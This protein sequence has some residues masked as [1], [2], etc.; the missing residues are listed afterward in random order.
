[1][2]EL[3]AL[4]QQLFLEYFGIDPKYVTF[5]TFVESLKN[6]SNSIIIESI[7]EGIDV[8][9]EG[10]FLSQMRN[11]STDKDLNLSDTDIRNKLKT[12]NDEKALPDNEKTVT[13]REIQR[14]ILNKLIFAVDKTTSNLQQAEDLYSR[15]IE[16]LPEHM[17]TLLNFF[18][19]PPAIYS[20]ENQLNKLII[21]NAKYDKTNPSRID[22]SQGLHVGAT[23]K[24]LQ[25][26]KRSGRI[27][28]INSDGTVRV[29]WNQGI[30]NKRVI[31]PNVDPEATDKDGE[32]LYD[33]YDT[34]KAIETVSMNKPSENDEGKQTELIHKLA[35]PEE[36]ND[37]ERISS[38]LA[39]ADQYIDT[40]KH[41]S[42]PEK[43][44]LKLMT[45]SENVGDLINKEL[46]AIAKK[47]LD[48]KAIT[49]KKGVE[50]KVAQ[51]T[52]DLKDISSLYEEI[53]NI[54][55]ENATTE[56]DPAKMPIV[57]GLKE[58][59]QIPYSD[60]DKV[61]HGVIQIGDK[62]YV[63]AKS[64]AGVRLPVIRAKDI[65][66]ALFNIPNG[67]ARWKQYK[68]LLAKH[69]NKQTKSTVEEEA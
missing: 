68:E 66:Q 31:E 48:M 49:T 3:K 52:E 5:K 8:I 29:A 60:F 27:T 15:C 62:Y 57:L 7:V 64:E 69:V 26:P 34:S 14:I 21:N 54:F 58:I 41:I 47:M 24:K 35:T 17:N 6:E 13:E 4:A 16:K 19:E 18:N 9:I 36:S 1:M 33:V 43:K 38:K 56:I 37:D 50:R 30:G 32:N 28:A 51:I 44:F 25:P 67:D 46:N 23:I 61:L 65:G 10:V 63:P 2:T 11:N 59:E 53:T 45:S 42:E 40:A 20:F 55:S 39:Q 22:R 12:F